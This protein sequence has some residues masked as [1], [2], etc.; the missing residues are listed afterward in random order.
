MQKVKATW[1]SCGGMGCFQ[2]HIVIH[3]LNGKLITWTKGRERTKRRSCLGVYDILVPNHV[4]VEFPKGYKEEPVPGA[5]G[6]VVQSSRFHMF[7]PEYKT[8]FL[9]WK[10]DFL[11]KGF[12]V[13]WGNNGE[14]IEERG[15]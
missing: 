2:T 3:E 14:N 8:E 4:Q 9:A 11:A 6:L 10:K 12:A 7:A 15:C 1:V 13:I 5:P